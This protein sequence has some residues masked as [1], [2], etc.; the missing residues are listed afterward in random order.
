M[1]TPTRKRGQSGWPAAI[2]AAA[3]CSASAGP[4]GSHGVVRL[5]ARLVED[6]EDLVA[7]ELGHLAA[8][9]VA[10]HRREAAE[11]RDEHRVH[12]GRAALLR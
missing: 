8:E 5:V 12:L 6:G 2:S 4:R 3:R 9:L 7:D 1:L 11:V 10:D